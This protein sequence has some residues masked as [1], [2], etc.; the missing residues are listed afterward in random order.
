MIGNKT[1]IGKSLYMYKLNDAATL[2]RKAK[3]KLASTPSRLDLNI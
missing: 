2:E 1:G 3:H